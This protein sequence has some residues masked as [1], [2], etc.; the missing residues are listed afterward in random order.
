MKKV[1]NIA[2]REKA[3]DVLTS[4]F[5]KDPVTLYMSDTEASRRAF[6]NMSVKHL[7]QNTYLFENKAVAVWYKSGEA[8]KKSIWQYFKSP[9]SFCQMMYHSSYSKIRELTWVCN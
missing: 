7:V 8:N 5:S 6:F 1:Q 4:A 2:E 9:I 3:V